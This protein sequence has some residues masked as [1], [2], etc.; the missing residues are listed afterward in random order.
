MLTTTERRVKRSQN[1]QPTHPGVFLREVVIPGMD[2]S[3]TQIAVDI[4]ISR[5]TLHAIL[6][7]EQP[8]TPQMAV[9]LAK[10]LGNSAEFWLNMQ[11]AHD[12]WNATRDVDTSAIRQVAHVAE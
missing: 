4:G 6:K 8:V 9:R 7:G 11:S 5:Q 2:R 12:L 3:K 1:R 10:Y